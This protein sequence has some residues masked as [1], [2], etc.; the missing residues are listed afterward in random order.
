MIYPRPPLIIL[1]SMVRRGTWAGNHN[2]ACEMGQNMGLDF[3]K[4][5]HFDFPAGSMFW[6]RTKAMEKLLT[7]PVTYETFSQSISHDGSPAHAVE[8]MFG[9]IPILEGYSLKSVFVY[10]PEPETPPEPYVPVDDQ[11]LLER[12]R[13]YKAR[14]RPGNRIAV[15]TAM[16]GGY[17]AIPTP[18]ELD[19][20]V[21]YICFSD[22][23][24]EGEH[25][26][27][28]RPLDYFNAD[29]TR[30]TRYYKLHP[31][32]Y[33]SKYDYV[34]WIDS[35]ILIRKNIIHKLIDTYNAGGNPIATIRHPERSC[36]YAE[37][38]ACQEFHFDDKTLIETQI[39]RYRKAGLPEH[40]GLPE[41][42]IYVTAPQNP[43]SIKLFA[44]WWQ[45]LENGSRRDQ[46]S[47]MYVLFKNGFSYTPLFNNYEDGPRYNIKDFAYFLHNNQ[48]NLMNPSVYHYPFFI[49]ERK[50][51]IDDDLMMPTSALPTGNPKLDVIVPVHNALPD[52]KNC[53]ASLMPTLGNRQNVILVNDGSDQDTTA[54][55]TDFVADFP[56][57][58]R[59]IVHEKAKGY[60]IS[61]NEA[62]RSSSA[63]YLVFLNSDTIVPPNWWR[64]LVRCAESS[65][66]IGIVGP[67][68]N[69][70]SW[71]TVPVLREGIGYCINSL[72]N[73]ISV[74]DADRICEEAAIPGF[75][76]KCEVINGFCFFVKRVVFDR[77]GLFD[78]ENFPTG[79]GEEDDLCF[80]AVNAGFIS[81]IAV[82][83]Y[84][85]HAKSK[86]F[87]HATRQEL[88]RQNQQKFL[89]KHSRVRLQRECKT[90]E[91]FPELI[92][93][94]EQINKRLEKLATEQRERSR[95]SSR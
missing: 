21:D 14:K 88:C 19:P 78:E 1:N 39:E 15:Y 62:V 81:A 67:L 7:M 73:G 27:E 34:I 23:I 44:D 85:F 24:L 42:N 55:L 51:T 36:T 46:L 86:S 26:W 31:H 3:K 11:L 40:D 94:R 18:E 2:I 10:P 35:N 70:A 32:A 48:V 47:I 54:F 8:R 25:P 17:D 29:R 16:A 41:T 22:S 75:Y 58:I 89:S 43:H 84:V 91:N 80:R 20:E 60:T 68:S 92:R 79:Y 93:Q 4:I 72:P 45:E 65:P 87:G 69:A 64:K 33:F 38:K 66:D 30:I 61:I 56:E 71:Q 82:D 74:A 83:T 37:A 90:L 57:K 53:L 9:A 5:E 28:M 59:L 49:K 52:L 6:A 63:D 76:P 50:R 77:I 13:E 95:Q 12:I